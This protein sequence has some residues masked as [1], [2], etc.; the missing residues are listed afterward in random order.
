MNHAKWRCKSRKALPQSTENQGKTAKESPGMPEFLCK[1][2]PQT[3]NRGLRRKHF[4]FAL[5]EYRA[6]VRHKLGPWIFC[7]RRGGHT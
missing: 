6:I 7:V 5:T 2:L 4:R 1:A 3:L